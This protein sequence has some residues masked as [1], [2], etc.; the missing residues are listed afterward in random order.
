[1]RKPLHLLAF[2]VLAGLVAAGCSSDERGIGD[3]PVGD[4]HEEP[5]QVWVNVDRFPNVSAFCIGANGVYTTTR[6]AA[7]T[8]VQ[9]DTNCAEGGVLAGG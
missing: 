5:R 8:V 2:T 1:M 4:Q 7:P 9:D 6:E 3:A